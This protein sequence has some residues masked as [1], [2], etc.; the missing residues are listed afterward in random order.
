MKA[1]TGKMRMGIYGVFT[2]VLTAC[3]VPDQL[4]STEWSAPATTLDSSLQRIQTSLTHI[5]KYTNDD[6]FLRIVRV[7]ECYLLVF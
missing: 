6:P 3:I 5:F 4:V 1:A 2:D 7:N